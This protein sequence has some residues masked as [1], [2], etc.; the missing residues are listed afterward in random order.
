[1]ENNQKTNISY[2]NKSFEYESS[3]F[4]Y[5]NYLNKKTG[6][7]KKIQNNFFTPKKQAKKIAFDSILY[8]N[9]DRTNTRLLFL[10]SKGKI[11]FNRS[12][13]NVGFKKAQR[14]KPFGAKILFDDFYSRISKFKFKRFIVCVKGFGYGRRS[15]LKSIVGSRIRRK[16]VSI[17]DITCLPHNGTRSRRYPRI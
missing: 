9:A 1:M 12:Q 16:C 10:D 14:K 7:L 4:I 5:S 3:N 8:V 2:V 15:I 6:R 17:V 11:I 13:G